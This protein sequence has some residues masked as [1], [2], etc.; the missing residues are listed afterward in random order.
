MLMN[1]ELYFHDGNFV[2]IS[3]EGFDV[4]PM[5]QIVLDLYRDLNASGRSRCVISV[6]RF[7]RFSL[8]GDFIEIHKN[9]F[10]GAIEDGSIR[11][12]EGGQQVTLRIAGG[13]LEVCG[14]VA[15]D[16]P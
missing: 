4:G 5:C 2:S 11:D 1:D 10:A 3:I 14:K 13:Y 9:Y 16:F 7:S 15:V 8:L 12:V 6:S